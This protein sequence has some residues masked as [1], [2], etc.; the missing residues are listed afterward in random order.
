MISLDQRI[1][2]SRIAP[3]TAILA[4]II[5][6]GLS[7]GIAQG[8]VDPVSGGAAR[9]ALEPDA[10]AKVTGG[11]NVLAVPTYPNTVA[12]FGLNARRPVGFT[13]G[14]SAEGRIEYNRHRSTTGR[15]V[16]VPVVLMEAFISGTP[17]PNGT[18]GKAAIVGECNLGSTCPP[19][20]L[21]VVVYVE[22]NSDSGAGSDVFKIYFCETTPIL[23]PPNF[24]G[25]SLPDCDGPEGG[26]VRSGNIQVRSTPGEA[27]EMIMTAAAAGI[28]PSS[29]NFNGVE[30]AGGVIGV[31]ARTSSSSANGDLEVQFTGMSALGLSQLV[32][33]TGW[34]T[35]ASVVGGTATLNGTATL[36]MGEGPPPTGGHTLVV[37]LTSTGVTVNIGGTALPTLP[38]TDGFIAIE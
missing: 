24:G 27:G 31:G 16:N 2:R 12:S 6:I 1:R 37:T 15:H 22:D 19:G 17:T 28:F 13:G 8:R 23:P 36:D 30:L 32:T 34:I 4:L 9:L 38:K 29:A 21:S 7:P 3:W 14:G 25:G 18:G 35:S 26:N 11:G 33:I 5:G 10:I 20:D